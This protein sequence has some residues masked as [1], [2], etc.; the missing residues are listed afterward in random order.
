MSG[1]ELSSRKEL[2][3]TDTKQ[4]KAGA[5][6]MGV[7]TMIL[8]TSHVKGRKAENGGVFPRSAWHTQLIMSTCSEIRQVW[9]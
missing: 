1:K 2:A 9:V 8:D 4:V 7:I 5:R 3:K 6:D